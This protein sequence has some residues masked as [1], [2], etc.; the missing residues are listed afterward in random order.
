[1]IDIE[2]GEGPVRVLGVTVGGV[3]TTEFDAT[4]AL[5]WPGAFKTSTV[6][7]AS[8]N[9]I[10]A[11]GIQAILQASGHS[12]V[13]RC[14]DEDGLLRVVTSH[15]PDIVILAEN[16]VRR[17]EAQKAVFRLRAS[18]GSLAIVYLLEQHDA[19]TASDLQD[20]GVEGILLST[21]GTTSVIDCVESVLHGR[22][23]VDPN[24]LRYLA[25]A[26]RR[27]QIAGC[28]TLREAEIADL[29]LR[30]L[31]NKH[32]AR[33]LQVREGTVKMH[34]HHI[35]TKL[36]LGSRMQLALWTEP[37]RVQMPEAGDADRRYGNGPNRI[38][39]MQPD[40]SRAAPVRRR[41]SDPIH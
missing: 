27:S 29:V 11:T 30:G 1:V 18:N 41:K 4:V 36:H 39:P 12:V 7:F 28:L 33:E 5:P 16:V 38:P 13:A 40:S 15:H 8:R 23:W 14:S 24:L 37:A 2:M 20:L 9:E 6:V 35:Y 22:K 26:E 25:M 19:V 10:A 21:A 3:M 32:I 34:L 31:S 17:E